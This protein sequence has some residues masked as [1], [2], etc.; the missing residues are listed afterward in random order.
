MKQPVILSFFAILILI[1]IACNVSAVTDPQKMTPIHLET[2]GDRTSFSGEYSCKATDTVLLI[3]DE[4]G[5]ATL[6]TTGP[7]FVDYIN[8][9]P[10]SSGFQATYNIVGLAD[11]DGLLITFTSCNEGGFSA[12]GEISYRDDKPVGH[13]DCTHSTGDQAGELAISLWVPAGDVSP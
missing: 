3:V 5:V 6:S 1:S 11:P 8:C 7:V 10:D 12:E 9:T 4:D 13:V 2:T